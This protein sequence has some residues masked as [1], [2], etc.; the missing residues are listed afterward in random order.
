MNVLAL[1]GCGQEGKTTVKDLL[2]S[3]DVSSVV[4][5]DIKIE[6]ADKFKAELANDKVSTV[7]MD[8]ND[9][10]KLLALM[11]E[12]DVVVNFIGPFYRY[13]IQV[14]EAAIETR[15][16]YV[17][18]CDDYD[19]T[20]EMLALN[21]K[22]KD[23]GITVLI[24]MGASPGVTNLLAKHGADKLEQVDD[25][26]MKWIVTVAD[27][28]EV[29]ASA[30]MD[31]AMHMIDGNV[32]QY[33][34]GKSQDVPALTGS[35]T[36]VFPV[37]GESEVYYVG[38]AEPVTLPLYIKGLK[39]CTNKGG[40][41]GLDEELKMLSALGLTGTKPI[42]IKGEKIAP[43]DIGVALLG[44]LPMPEELPPPVSAIKV[45]IR[46]RRGDETVQYV[47]TFFGR[48]TDWTGIPA[49]IGTQMVGRGAIK[50]KGVLAPEGCVDTNAFL[51]E[52]AK[53]GMEVEEVEEKSRVLG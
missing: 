33:L 24:G 9:R 38:H 42:D 12:T 43:K 28:D 2:K 4:I 21:E 22:A 19:A 27:V 5:A 29:G 35:E 30:A 10:D 26:E 40:V 16:N 32:P 8:V 6:N 23:A 50:A 47:Y 18:I 41:P 31:H 36:A 25:I 20:R 52:I 37:I 39:T 14:I 7:Q 51:A 44:N 3:E 17:D 46:G 48:M 45:W 34:E 15:R 53:R 49:S 13:G 1:G 11:R